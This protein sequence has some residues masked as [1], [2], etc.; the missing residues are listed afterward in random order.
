[1]RDIFQIRDD[2]R[3]MRYG[4]DNSVR[5]GP[6]GNSRGFLVEIFGGGALSDLSSPSLALPVVH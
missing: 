3:D 6:R 4:I 5:V 1:M 2:M